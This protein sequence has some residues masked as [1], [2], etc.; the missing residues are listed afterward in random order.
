[1][2][3]VAVEAM[4]SGARRVSVADRWDDR[5]VYVRMCDYPPEV[6][7]QVAAHAEAM[8]GTPY[9]FSDYLALALRRFGIRSRLL[10]RWISRVDERD[11]PA[12]AI[13]S[14]LA[15]AA[16]SRAGICVFRDGRLSQDVIPGA[17]FY[18]LLR[19]GG[20]AFWPS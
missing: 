12:R 3:P 6:R 14:Q 5:F 11:Y 19:V 4:P 7:A 16:C 8:V 18:Q 15:D 17:L 1:M 13:C 20:R 10:D 9:G 2:A